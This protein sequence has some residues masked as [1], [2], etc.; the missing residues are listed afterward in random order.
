MATSEARRHD[1][2]T[3]LEELL[4]TERANTL[5]AYLPAYEI[6]ELATKADIRRLEDRLDRL[7]DRL[8]AINE[9]LDRFFLTQS[10]GLIAIVGTLVAAVLL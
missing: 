4:G 10:A 9:R 6:T 1:L 5:M 2:Y 8:D 3:G 7:D